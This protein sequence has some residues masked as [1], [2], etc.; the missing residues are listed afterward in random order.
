MVRIRKS[1]RPLD[2]CCARADLMLRADEVRQANY[3]NSTCTQGFKAT[4]T[5][6]YKRASKL[7][8]FSEPWAVRAGR[9]HD[10]EGEITHR[11]LQSLEN[12]QR[13]PNLIGIHFELSSTGLGTLS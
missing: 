10:R 13:S 1:F 6:S 12:I 7:L 8:N 2:E 3:I 9:R 4:R 5:R 11:D